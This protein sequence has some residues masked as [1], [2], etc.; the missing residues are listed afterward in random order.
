MKTYP[1]LLPLI[2]TSEK[3]LCFCFPCNEGNMQLTKS[4]M[5]CIGG[6]KKKLL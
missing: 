5:K 6:D 4:V 2:S 1:T 3:S